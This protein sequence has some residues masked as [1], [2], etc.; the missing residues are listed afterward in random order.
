MNE[1]TFTIE[2][3]EVTFTEIDDGVMIHDAADIN[4]DGDI[5]MIYEW[6]PEDIDDALNI[7]ESAR[8]L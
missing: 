3:R 5:Y 7:I 1:I 6:M 2:G 8:C 4:H